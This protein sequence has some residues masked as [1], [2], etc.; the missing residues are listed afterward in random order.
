MEQEGGTG[1]SANLQQIKVLRLTCSTIPPMIFHLKLNTRN[2]EESCVVNLRESGV[3]VMQPPNL[4]L[5]HDIPLTFAMLCRLGHR[6][7]MVRIKDQG[8]CWKKG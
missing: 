2:H 7:G 8:N 3:H 6:G 4:S 1:Q 5:Y